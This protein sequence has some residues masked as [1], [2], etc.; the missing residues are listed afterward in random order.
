VVTATA[1]SASVSFG[2]K[3]LG[4]HLACDMGVLHRVLGY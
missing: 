2:G 1:D 3:V 4:R